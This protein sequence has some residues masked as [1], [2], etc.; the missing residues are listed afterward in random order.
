MII[1]WSKISDSNDQFG[2]KIFRGIV[3]DDARLNWESRIPDIARLSESVA[4]DPALAAQL[5]GRAAEFS[6]VTSKNTRG[7]IE[8]FIGELAMA[9]WIDGQR[10]TIGEI[11]QVSGVLSSS[12]GSINTIFK[13]S[14]SDVLK[15]FD[16]AGMV[17]DSKA[18]DQAI[19]AIGAI[20]IV[21]WIIKA[22]FE[23]SKSIAGIVEASRDSNAAAARDMM[24]RQLSI[25]I[26]STQ[27]NPDANDFTAKAFFGALSAGESQRIIR[28]AYRMD[29]G[30]PNMGFQAEGVYSKEGDDMASGWVVLGEA[31]GN[32]GF[33]PGS[34]SMSRALFFPSGVKGAPNSCGLGCAAGAVR[35]LGTLYPTAQNLCTSWWSQVN[36]PGPS[37][38]TLRPLDAKSE[39]ETYIEQMFALA[40]NVMKGWTCAPTGKV[41]TDKF[42]C[43]SPELTCGGGTKKSKS[44]MGNCDHGNRGKTLTI[45]DDFGR[46]S[47]IVLYGYLC[48]LFFGIEN[49][50]EKSRGGL[51]QLPRVGSGS[52]KND[53]GFDYYRADALDMSKST[54][55]SALETLYANQRAGLKSLQCMYVAGDSQNRDRYP[56]F[57]DSNLRNLWEQS[58]T[59]VFS[60]GAWK[61]VSFQDMPDGEAKTAFYNHAKSRGIADVENLNRP[62]APG[63]KPSSGCGFQGSKMSLS[64]GKQIPDDPS[65]PQKPPMNGAVVKAMLIGDIGG[66]K[67]SRKKGSS[68]LP[69]MLGAGALALMFMKGRK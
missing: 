37:M 66:A 34:S 41:F 33:V 21:G 36:Q 22:V 26:G 11:A 13:S 49:P 51:D 24:A 14:R 30:S 17:L 2:G 4:A 55:V 3:S 5:G 58:V 1:P 62:C 31:T 60:S 46:S 10:Q 42:K 43:Y 12:L 29:P 68:A 25:P 50:F 19:S 48:R 8:Q 59:D 47:H 52:Y 6:E 57:E 45:P 38:Y 32:L 28:P 64:A 15:G 16:V 40:Q 39:W 44:G 56:A 23:I 53:L 35:D 18:F 69:L 54:P 9:D 67:K 63:E 20:P 65:M 61:R 7:A 27:F